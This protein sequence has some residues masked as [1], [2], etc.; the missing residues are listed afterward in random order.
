MKGRVEIINN[1]K[2]V[3][4][5]KTENNGYS[6]IEVIDSYCPELGDIISGPLEELGGETLKCVSDGVSFDVY[7]QD[8]HAS[9]NSAKQMLINF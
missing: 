3:I 8:I 2:G 5:V 6:V 7:I 1:A 9:F 4:A